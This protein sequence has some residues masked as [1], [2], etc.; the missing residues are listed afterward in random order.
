[1]VFSFSERIVVLAKEPPANEAQLSDLRSTYPSLPSEYVELMKVG[2]EIEVEFENGRYLRV[3]GPTGCLEMDDAYMISA[4]IDGAIPV[5][6][7]G[8]GHAIYYHTGQA[9][10]GLYCSEYGDLDPD[11]S[12][13]IA[14]TLKALLGDHVG[15]ER[16][17]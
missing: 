17:P 16:L 7:D 6:D 9:G 10:W 5:G 2:T 12:I 15:A 8:G 11:S 1:M 3:W 4:Y 13:W 14:P